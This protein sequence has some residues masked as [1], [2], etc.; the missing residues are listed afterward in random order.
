MAVMKE[1][2][3]MTYLLSTPPKRPQPVTTKKLSLS[4]SAAKF[5][6][7]KCHGFVVMSGTQL[8]C[9]NDWSSWIRFIYIF[10]EKI[11]A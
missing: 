1:Q 7:E 11:R 2:T 6:E 10:D 3:N 8:V 9:V 4:F 5:H